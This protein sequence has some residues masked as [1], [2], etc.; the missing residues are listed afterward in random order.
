MKQMFWKIPFRIGKLSLGVS[1]SFLSLLLTVVLL[2]LAFCGNLAI[3]TTTS[4][5]LR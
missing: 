3:D 4:A 2:A 5:I 1:S